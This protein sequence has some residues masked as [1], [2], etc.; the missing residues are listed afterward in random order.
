MRL[1]SVR[2]EPVRGV[3]VRVSAV[4]VGVRARVRVWVGAEEPVRGEGVPDLP[5][6]PELR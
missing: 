5:V 6:A 4:R 1:L 3:R 2:K